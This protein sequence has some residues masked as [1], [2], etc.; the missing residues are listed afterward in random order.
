MMGIGVRKRDHC[1][2]MLSCLTM[3][4]VSLMVGTPAQWIDVFV[5][6]ASQETWVV[7]TGGCDSSEFPSIALISLETTM[8]WAVVRVSESFS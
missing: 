1:S 3:V 6:T 4:R 7:G 5:S 8:I 2:D